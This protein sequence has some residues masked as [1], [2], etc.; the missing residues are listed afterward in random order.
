LSF[1]DLS[2]MVE[3]ATK[4]EGG[5][6]QRALEILAT[7]PPMLELS[8]F[9]WNAFTELGRDRPVG[10]N[11]TGLIPLR[12]IREYADDFYLD[13]DE[14]HRFRKVIM[15]VDNRRQVLIDGKQSKAAAKANKSKH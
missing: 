14:Y 8:R 10:M 13:D 2:K 3:I 6:Q 1:D 12:S 15:A 9:Y 11:G 7:Q 4:A 5:P